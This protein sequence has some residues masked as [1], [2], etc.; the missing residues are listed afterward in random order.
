MKRMTPCLLIA[1][2]L[3][4]GI[5]AIQAQ[6][7]EFNNSDIGAT[8]KNRQRA[9]VDTLKNKNLPLD[10]RAA[11][12]KNL[13][14]CYGEI[15]RE[16]L[17]FAKD[18][19]NEEELRL[20][21]VKAHT[22]TNDAIPSILEILAS[23]KRANAYLNSNLLQHLAQNFGREPG[24]ELYTNIHQTVK[25]LLRDERQPVRREAIFHAG[26]DQRSRRHYDHQGRIAGRKKGARFEKSSTGNSQL[27]R[28]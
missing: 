25:S 26:N 13:Q 19:S 14:N 1:I 27:C 23:D 22:Y 16:L 5:E 18:D 20:L 24:N 12:A 15:G 17:D 8:L 11:A 7:I 6:Q 4:C 3:F 2:V 10:V 21:A 9:L 28:A